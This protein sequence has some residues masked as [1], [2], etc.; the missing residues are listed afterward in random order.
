MC[1]PLEKWLDDRRSSFCGVYFDTAFWPVTWMVWFSC[2]TD[3]RGEVMR[4]WQKLLMSNHRRAELLT[5]LG[6]FLLLPVIVTPYS[7]G[8]PQAVMRGCVLCGD[9]EKKK[10]CLKWVLRRW[11]PHHFQIRAI[12]PWFILG[13]RIPQGFHL[14]KDF[15][16]KNVWAINAFSIFPV[17]PS[18]LS[19]F[20]CLKFSYLFSLFG[21]KEWQRIH[22]GM[23]MAPGMW[24][25]FHSVQ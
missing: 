15:R 1:V 3:E 25:P 12:L 23:W 17:Y 16:S 19:L 6:L 5:D 24:V 9:R 8:M 11:V 14:K 13:T 7:T 21:E 18:S 4:C 20:S 22:G 10:E 2:C